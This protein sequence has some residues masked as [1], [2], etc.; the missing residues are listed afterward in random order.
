MA[1]TH[2]TTRALALG[3]LAALGGGVLVGNVAAQARKPHAVRPDRF[4]ALAREYDDRVRG[5]ERSLGVDGDRA[6]LLSRARG[7]VLEVAAGTWRNADAYAGAGVLSLTL[8]DASPE[9]L[10]VARGKVGAAPADVRGK[11]ADVRAVPA[12]RLSSEFPARSFDTVVDTFGVCSFADPVRALREMALVLADDGELLLL[13]HGRVTNPNQWG[14][15]LINAL[16]DLRAGAHADAWGCVHN[17]DVLAA[18]SSAGFAVEDVRYSQLSTVVSV[19]ARKR[20]V[21]P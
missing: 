1:T 8:T 14:A 18:V 3:A 11:L 5:S 16:L 9:M 6:R 7:R 21:D 15:T 4:A 13:E 10:A 19:V 17:R 12:D 20:R 2:T